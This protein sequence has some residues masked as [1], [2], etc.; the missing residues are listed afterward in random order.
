VKPGELGPV[1]SRGAWIAGGVVLEIAGVG[2]PAAYVYEK[3]K[4]QDVGGSI[5]QGTIRLVWHE[6]VHSR[7]GLAILIAGAVVFAVGAML[8]AR[9]FA[10][11]WLTLLVAVPVAAVVSM[12]ALGLAVLVIAL[13]V[14]GIGELVDLGG[15]GG[16]GGGG[17][18]GG[19][20]GDV[21]GNAV[22]PSTGTTA[23]YDPYADPSFSGARKR[24][25]PTESVPPPGTS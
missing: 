10:K 5:T 22:T 6:A 15:G 18:S 14:A 17:S 25:P 7:T 8:V 11:H 2:G 21:I 1:K 23:T 4:K 20:I 3:A 13:I 24:R 9:P 12:L 19:S 16:G